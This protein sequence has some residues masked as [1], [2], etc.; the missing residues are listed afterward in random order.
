MILCSGC[1]DGIHS[2][3]VAYLKAASELGENGC[4]W[5]SVLVASDDYIRQ[6]KGREP[7]WNQD[8]RARAVLGIRYVNRAW[9][10]WGRYDTAESIRRFKPRLFVKGKDW[11]GRL[12]EAVVSACDEVGA[13]IVFVDTEEK[14]TSE[15]A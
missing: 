1:F 9:K 2:G 11:E 5:V 15:A 6:A 4:R 14:H 8:Q 12:P 7:R 3:H 10:E 13:R